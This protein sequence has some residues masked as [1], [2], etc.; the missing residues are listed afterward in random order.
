M[1]LDTAPKRT[2]P[3]LDPL[4]AQ[5]TFAGVELLSLLKNDTMGLECFC[6]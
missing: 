6:I 4:K 2:K 1:C 3:G 5:Q